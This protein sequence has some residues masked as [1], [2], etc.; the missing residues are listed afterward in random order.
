MGSNTLYKQTKKV[1]FKK[2]AEIHV[3]LGK[4]Y[5]QCFQDKAPSEARLSP[6]RDG[7]GTAEHTIFSPRVHPL[8]LSPELFIFHGLPC[9][10]LCSEG[11][12]SSD[13]FYFFL[14]KAMESKLLVG[15]K[16]I[17]DHTN[18]QQKILEQKRQEIA[19]QVTFH[20]FLERMRWG[21]VC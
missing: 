1:F 17:V 14:T 2:K 20:S 21:E 11:D 4:L 9:E 10:G 15:G 5:L 16:N 13:G 3:C 8:G 12:H 6:T 7:K 18:E 19:E